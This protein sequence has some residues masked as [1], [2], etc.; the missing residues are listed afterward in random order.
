[1]ERRDLLT[2]S[3]SGR[4]SEPLRRRNWVIFMRNWKEDWGASPTERRSVG[5]SIQRPQKWSSFRVTWVQSRAAEL[6][7]HRW[8][9]AS[10][11]IYPARRRSPTSLGKSRV[12]SPWD[13]CSAWLTR[14]AT[15]PWSVTRIAVPAAT[16]ESLAP[17]TEL[18]SMMG[19]EGVLVYSSFDDFWHRGWRDW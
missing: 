3:R 2:R 17:F 6:M 11:K 8:G 5:K 12:P 7:G 9:A 13:N 16:V 19:N 15:I 18:T 1:M 10:G 4:F 14:G